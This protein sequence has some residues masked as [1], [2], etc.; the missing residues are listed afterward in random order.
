MNLK[1][2][3]TTALLLSTGIIAV[4]AFADLETTTIRTTTVPVPG[5]TEITTVK[6]T[7]TPDYPTFVIPNTG[8]YFIIDP[9]T[10]NVIGNYDPSVGLIDTK[11][12]QPGS[13]IINKE[14]GRVIAAFDANG[15]TIELTVAPA[16]NPFVIA[17]DT[18]YAKIEAMINDCTGRG[19]M[20]AAEAAALR[21]ELGRIQSEEIA[22]KQSSGILTYSEALQVALDLNQLEDRFKPFLPKA[23]ETPLI[24]A[25]II[26]TNNQ[27]VIV[28]EI[29]Y[30]QAKLTQRVDDEYSAGRLSSDQVSRLKDQ[31]NAAAALRTRYIKDGHLT[32][33]GKQKVAA[34]LDAINTKM[35]QDVAI[36][37]AK[38]SKIGIK[39][40]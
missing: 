9:V 37:N 19:V 35:D 38:R 20:D 31:L 2:N 4:P 16:Y 14:S 39:V 33:S 17:I 22:Y 7:T 21:T 1:R 36:I 26:T 23:G 15:R 34:K 28:D 30:R 29:E 5:G 24:G 18:R 13:V 10:G 25:H 11:V 8:S 3:F 27:L 40:N 12:I 6:T 32:E